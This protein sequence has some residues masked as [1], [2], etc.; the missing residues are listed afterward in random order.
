MPLV[1]VQVKNYFNEN[2][3]KQI[4]RMLTIKTEQCHRQANP[5]GLSI[6]RYNF[7]FT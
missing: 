7:Y 5:N 3:I 2:T 1:L 4:L 6:I